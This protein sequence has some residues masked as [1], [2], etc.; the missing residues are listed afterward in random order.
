M[1]CKNIDK[2][3]K[4]NFIINDGTGYQEKLRLLSSPE[5]MSWYIYCFCTVIL[6]SN[7]YKAISTFVQAVRKAFFGKDS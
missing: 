1:L 4:Y 7:I 6:D 5:I 3:G 2:S